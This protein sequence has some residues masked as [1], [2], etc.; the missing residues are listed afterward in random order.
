MYKC[1][2]VELPNGDFS[3]N[4]QMDDALKIPSYGLKQFLGFKTFSF[5]F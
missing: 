3:Q 1:F 2:L 5:F 4:S